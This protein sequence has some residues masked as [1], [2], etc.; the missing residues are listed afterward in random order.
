ME[1]YLFQLEFFG[2]PHDGLRRQGTAVPD[3][4][5]LFPVRGNLDSNLPVAYCRIEDATAAAYDFDHTMISGSLTDCTVVLHYRFS[6]FTVPSRKRHPWIRSR[7][8]A[9]RRASQWL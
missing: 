8:A 1:P 2:G 6:G 3:T 9:V 4:R 7:L 5:L